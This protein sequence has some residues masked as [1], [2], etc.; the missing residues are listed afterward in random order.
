MIK[1]K[2]VLEIDLWCEAH[3]QTTL[4]LGSLSFYSR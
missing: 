2:T 4:K 1:M 3:K